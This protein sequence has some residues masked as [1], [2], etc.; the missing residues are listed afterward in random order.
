MTKNLQRAINIATSPEQN[1]KLVLNDERYLSERIICCLDNS[2]QKRY[3]LKLSKNDFEVFNAVA[4]RCRTEF[5][6]RF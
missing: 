5:E 1:K 6:K 3:P 4:C 2:G